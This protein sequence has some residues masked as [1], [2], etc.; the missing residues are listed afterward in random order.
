MTKHRHWKTLRR[1]LLLDR[2]P[3]LKVYEDDIELPTGE[4][5]QG[6]IHMQTPG[7]AMIVPINESGEMGL[8]RS[9][10]RGVDDVDIQPPA[11]VL[12]EE[13]PLETARR[14]L[15]EETGCQADTWHP[16]GDVVLSGNYGAGRA[17]FF[18][19]TGCR[20]IQAPDSGDLEEQEVVWL[21]IEDVYLLYQKG[22]FRQM[23]STAALGLAF[24]KLHQLGLMSN[25]D[26]YRD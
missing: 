3:W 25:D 26:D 8:I 4:L 9:Y 10:K 5:V 1:T 13:G 6:Y 22:G 16:L 20:L 17:H 21:P 7:Y 24:A 14:E 12:E 18:L 2:S 15:L 19:A 23:G 11:G